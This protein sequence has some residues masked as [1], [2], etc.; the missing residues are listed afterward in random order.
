MIKHEA[1]NW[2]AFPWVSYFKHSDLFLTSQGAIFN[3][4]YSD[5]TSEI[6]KDSKLMTGDKSVQR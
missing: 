4:A 3:V 2:N 1:D 5:S 6:R